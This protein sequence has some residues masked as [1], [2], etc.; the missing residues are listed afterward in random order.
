MWRLL[1]LLQRIPIFNLNH[2][3]SNYKPSDIL[4]RFTISHP[5]IHTTIVGTRNFYH[6]E[7][8]LKA[9]ESGPLPTEIYAEV[10]RRLYAVNQEP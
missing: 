1:D 5:D 2:S 4:L 9:V 7:E 3:P 10:K 6:L 8:N